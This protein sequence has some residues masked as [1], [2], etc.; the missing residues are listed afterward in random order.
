MAATA[1]AYGNR[2][3]TI[4]DSVIS[5]NSTGLGGNAGEDSDTEIH[6]GGNGGAG[7]G[8]WSSGTLSIFDT[9]VSANITGWGGFGGGELSHGGNGGSGG[10]ILN[11]GSLS[12]T[13]CQIIDNS[14]G[15]G[16]VAVGDGPWPGNLD[17]A[18]HGG[19]GGGIASGGTLNVTSSLISGNTT[20]DGA[21][22]V[23]SPSFGGDGGFGGGISSGGSVYL[24][25]TVI[26]DNH[27]G[28]GG[29]TIRIGLPQ[30]DS[31]GDGGGGS[32]GGISCG[33][34]LTV[35][36]STITGNTTGD[37][38][39][40]H[41]AFFGNGG[42]IYSVNGPLTIRRCEISGNSAGLD[43]SGGGIF[44]QGSALVYD[45]TIAGN[46]A[47][48]FGG[49]IALTSFGSEALIS[50]CTISGNN[51]LNVGGGGIFVGNGPLTIRHSTITGN[52][53]P[54]S[55][56]G[57]GGILKLVDNLF[58]YGPIEVY[59][60]IVSGNSN[61]DVAFQNYDPPNTNHFLSL[62]YN[63]IGDGNGVPNFN[64]P[65]D[66]TGISNPLLGPLVDNGGPTRTRALNFSPALDSGDPFA[67]PGLFGVPEYDRAALR[68]AR[69]RLEQHR[70]A[71][72]RPWRI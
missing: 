14:T 38:G 6:P 49:G 2:V 72:D 31:A 47:N 19:S 21:D 24:L 8:I 44:S 15:D 10:G 33:G 56:Y 37:A 9:A 5:D 16:G 3:L 54:V 63:I 41:G 36:N 22:G 70:R 39:S 67:M 68:S 69:C 13:N 11:T 53:A 18:G 17:F 50:G 71:S 7:G 60:S 61:D 65:G 34:E 46:G 57:G 42:G 35:I 59:S 32:G 27:T 51:V 40:S 43:S 45:S 29:T 30:P 23:D 55:E 12:L 26:S 66:Q 20:G 58:S 25:N 4:T 48:D 64:Q 52:L 28:D 62:G 1:A